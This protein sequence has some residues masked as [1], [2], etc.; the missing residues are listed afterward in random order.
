MHA[1][2]ELA[3]FWAFGFLTLSIALVLLGIFAGA[4]QSDCELLSLSK[5]AV[6]AGVAALIEAA[7]VWLVAVFI[8][9]ASRGLALR[10]MIVPIIIVGLIYRVV[11]LESWSIFEAGLLLAFQVAVGCLLAS[12]IFGHFQAALMIVVVFGIILAVIAG[13][14]RSL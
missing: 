2:I 8:P 9:A 10:A 5:E 1:A 3:I 14:M 6:I 13:I 7:S 12:L 4:I 11:H